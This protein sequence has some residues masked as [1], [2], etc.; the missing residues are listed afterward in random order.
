MEFEDSAGRAGQSQQDMPT[1]DQAQLDAAVTPKRLR[2]IAGERYFERGEDYFA[3]NAVRSLRWRGGG[4]EAT[5]R[6][7]HK[8]RVRLWVENGQLD[9]ACDCPLGR[10][11]AFCKHCVATGLAW[12]AK[13]RPGA[14]GMETPGTVPFSEADVRKYLMGLDRE[15]LVALILEQADVDEQLD[16]RLRIRAA[17]NAGETTRRSVWK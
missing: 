11:G 4:V 17:G 14:N 13:P 12:H 2:R 1:D 9:H 15:E 7:T 5:V 16:R 6:G 8:Y 3:G 10:E